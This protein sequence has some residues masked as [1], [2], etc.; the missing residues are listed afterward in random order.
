MEVPGQVAV[1]FVTPKD[2]CDRLRLVSHH[3]GYINFGR[4]CI[5]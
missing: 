3:V 4:V 1:H 5:S 2:R